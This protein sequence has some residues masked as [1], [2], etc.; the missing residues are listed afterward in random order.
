MI[1]SVYMLE[2]FNL[3]FHM[4]AVFYIRRQH[5]LTSKKTM[6]MIHSSCQLPPIKDTRRW[7][8]VDFKGKVIMRKTFR[9]KSFIDG[10]CSTM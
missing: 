10:R 8:D 5:S 2:A 6:E 3:N 7:F 9:N 4:K 1:L